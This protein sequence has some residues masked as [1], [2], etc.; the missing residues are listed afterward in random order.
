[1]AAS[2]TMN[3]ETAAAT[4]GKMFVNSLRRLARQDDVTGIPTKT[5]QPMSTHLHRLCET[6]SA[7]VALLADMCNERTIQPK[8]VRGVV[9]LFDGSPV[10]A[11]IDIAIE[12][13][14]ARL[15]STRGKSLA[16]QSGLSISVSLVSKIARRVWQGRRVAPL[17]HIALTAAVETI[18]RTTIVNA[19]GDQRKLRHAQ[20]FS[21]ALLEWP[22][23]ELLS[24][25]PN[26]PNAEEDTCLSMEM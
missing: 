21:A 19:A 15:D 16:T 10:L 6:L 2:N 24:K 5:V 14:K 11:D 22:H 17:A 13:L 1:M 4:E 8:H 3:T 26:A 23:F 25:S 7:K 20:A 12:K 18:F 9:S